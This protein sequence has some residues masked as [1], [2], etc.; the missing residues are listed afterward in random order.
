MADEKHVELRKLLDAK[1]AD[2]DAKFFDYLSLMEW[3]IEWEKQFFPEDYI[4]YS[5]PAA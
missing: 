5:S 4:G 3:T 1:L 2:Y